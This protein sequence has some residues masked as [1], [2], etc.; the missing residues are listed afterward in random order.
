MGERTCVVLYPTLMRPSAFT[1]PAGSPT[2][3]AGSSTP[4]RHG[5]SCPA[6]DSDRLAL[7]VTRLTRA[8]VATSRERREIARDTAARRDRHDR[9]SWLDLMLPGADPDPPDTSA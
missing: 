9:T 4:G 7:S 5:A 8:V 3:C 2:P 1:T 6:A